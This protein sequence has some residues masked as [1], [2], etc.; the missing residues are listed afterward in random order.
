[1]FLAESPTAAHAVAAALRG[2]GRE[3]VLVAAGPVPGAQVVEVG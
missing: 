1:V 3:V 2:G